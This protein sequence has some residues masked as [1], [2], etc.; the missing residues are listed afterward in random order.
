MISN[1]HWYFSSV[2]SIF[3]I[4][5]DSPASLID[6]KSALF[7][8]RSS[9]FSAIDVSSLSVGF[10]EPFTIE[11]IRPLFCVLGASVSGASVS[12]ASVSGASVSGASV[13]G[14]SVSGASVSGASVS[15][16]SVS[17]ASGLVVSG[18]S[19]SGA[20]VSSGLGPGLS[21][22]GLGLGLSSTGL[23]EPGAGLFSFFASS[24]SRASLALV[25]STGGSPKN[26]AITPGSSLSG[27]S[28]TLSKRLGRTEAI[29]SACSVV[30]SRRD[31]TCSLSRVA[32]ARD[33]SLVTL[34][35]NSEYSVLAPTA[36]T[37]LR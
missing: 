28:A 30:F 15:G 4:A 9:A 26:V 8:V 22:P 3:A 2:T 11:P 10:L 5:K 21:S 1:T 19:I 37:T 29:I 7:F 34:V 6:S 25:G 17:G 35:I 36:A 14:A 32:T 23:S 18:I 16:A 27:V 20:S 13:S 31:T 24:F 33:A 12:G